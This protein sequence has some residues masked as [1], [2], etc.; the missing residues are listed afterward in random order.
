MARPARAQIDLQALRENYQWARQLTAG[1][2]ALAVVKADA[3]GHGAARVARALAGQ[4]DGFAVACLEEALE[5]RESGVLNPI[6]LLEGVFAPTELALVATHGLWITVHC[7]TQLE[8]LLSARLDRPLKVW[9]K[10]DSGMHRLGFA[11]QDYRAAYAALARSP[12]VSEI[13]A[14]S[15]FARADETDC[16]FSREQRATFERLTEDLPGA[17][18]IA[19]SAGILAWPVREGEW[20]RPGLALYGVSPL[21]GSRAGATPLRPAMAL[22]SELIAV[23]EVNAGEAIGYGTHCITQGITRVGV[24]AMGYADGYPRA[25]ANGTP[26]AVAGQRTQLLGRVSM[27]MLSVDLTHLPHAAIGDAVELWGPQI[28]IAEVASASQT[29][30]YEL[31]TRLTRRVERHYRNQ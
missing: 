11:P 6:L 12:Q 2:R 16:P 4:A 28:G 17:R 25:A 20:V 26:V 24:V 31:L 10:M 18:S 14:M 13:V 9:L 19:N 29:I 23:R 30:P 7:Q 15:H 21:S 1:S 5:L 3:Y 8:W 22:E 27:D